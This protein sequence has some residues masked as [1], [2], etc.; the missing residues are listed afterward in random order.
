MINSCIEAIID[1]IKQF[2]G[3]VYFVIGGA[4][5]VMLHLLALLSLGVLYASPPSQRTCSM[6]ESEP[7]P[8]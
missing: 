6:R 8:Q 3:E 7:T 2:W 1:Y 5:F 4:R